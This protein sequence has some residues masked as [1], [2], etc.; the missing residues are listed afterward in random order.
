MSPNESTTAGFAASATPIV[1]ARQVGHPS[2]DTATAQATAE[3]IRRSLLRPISLETP[4][5]S[6]QSPSEAAQEFHRALQVVLNGIPKGPELLRNRA[7]VLLLFTTGLM[8]IEAAALTVAH[9][10]DAGGA[11][12]TDS[13]LAANLTANKRERRLLWV[14]PQLLA[15]MDAYLAHR[16]RPGPLRNPR[17]YR[18]LRPD[19]PL[20]LGDRARVLTFHGPGEARRR[21]SKTF[22]DV[23]ARAFVGG[24]ALRVT[25]SRTRALLAKALYQEGAS[26]Q[27]VQE[28][29][30]Y[31]HKRKLMRLLG[32]SAQADRLVTLIRRLG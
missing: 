17:Q 28:F 26:L 22:V 5:A 23:C 30:G 7:L 6:L 18:G 3:A 20:I 25:P 31:A 4:L 21:G 27:E 24:K 11:V 29:L 1:R 12:R 10:L 8:P 16:P 14:N 19:D 2:D 15:A 13:A 9:Y 32:P